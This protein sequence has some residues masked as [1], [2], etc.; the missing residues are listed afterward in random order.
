MQEVCSRKYAFVATKIGE[1]M[2]PKECI[3]QEDQQGQIEFV[4]E[5]Q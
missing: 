2:Q 3:I 4:S 1:Q 5:L